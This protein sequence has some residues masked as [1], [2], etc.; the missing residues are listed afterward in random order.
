MQ[1]MRVFLVCV[2]GVGLGAMA[3][4]AGGIDAP[5]GEG[6][7]GPT[8]AAVRPVAPPAATTSTADSSANVAPAVPAPPVVSPVPAA[9]E[10]D[11]GLDAAADTD[12][13]VD[14]APPP[15]PPPCTPKLSPNPVA[16]GLFPDGCG[17][18]Y[19]QHRSDGVSTLDFAT[20]ANGYV[21]CSLVQGAPLDGFKVVM[22]DG[23][24]LND[25]TCV[26]TQ[27]GPDHFCCAGP[28]AGYLGIY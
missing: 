8:T 27:G 21:R 12:A 10:L 17:G 9:P 6:D 11:A 24:Q 19:A 5:P 4:C 7:A 26:Q 23:C 16:C 14:A 25:P 20:D 15:P 22:T 13:G 18:W 3:A 2:F 1:T 28:P